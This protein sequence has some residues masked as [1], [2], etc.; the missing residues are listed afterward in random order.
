M[1]APHYQELKASEIPHA[2]S[3]NGADVKVRVIA[4]EALGVRGAIKSRTPFSTCI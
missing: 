2:E 3:A 1:T 4:G